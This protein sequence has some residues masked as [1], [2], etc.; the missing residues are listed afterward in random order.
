MSRVVDPGWLCGTYGRYRRFPKVEDEKLL[1]EQQRSA[2]NFPIQ[3]AV[4]DAITLA[5]FNLQRYRRRYAEP[6]SFRMVLQ[7]H[8]ALL[9]EVPYQYVEWF[10]E[11]VVPTCI[12]GVPLWPRHLD[13]KPFA[14]IHQPYHFGVDTELFDH[15]GEPFPY[16][17]GLA[18]GIPEPYL[19]K[20]K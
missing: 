9:F 17:L 8:D 11:E 19:H 6:H 16:E 4:A 2:R 20:P 10:V 1:A 12:A 14:H 15:W 5:M 7:I 18:A 3:N 13:G